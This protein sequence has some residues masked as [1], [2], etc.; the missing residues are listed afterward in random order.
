MWKLFKIEMYNKLSSNHK[1]KTR[2][3]DDIIDT[4][5]SCYKRHIDVQSGGGILTPSPRDKVVSEA[6]KIR[7]RA[8]LSSTT[9]RSVDFL[10]QLSAY[11]YSYWTMRVIQGPVGNTIVLFPG[12]FKAPSTPVNKTGHAMDFIDSLTVALIQHKSTMSGITINHF[13]PAI[14]PWSGTSFTS[15]DEV[16]SSSS[17]VTKMVG[18]LS[19]NLNDKINAGNLNPEDKNQL[20]STFSLNMNNVIQPIVDLNKSIPDIGRSNVIQ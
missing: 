1:S 13:P 11:V 4:I 6:L 20:I 18:S 15:F 5:D 2:L 17:I 3:A 14:T 9:P 19:N 10:N 7:L 16:S 8:N 12:I